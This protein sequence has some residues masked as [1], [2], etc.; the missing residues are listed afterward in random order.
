MRRSPGS[1][2][3]C[4]ERRM[5]TRTE[6][7]TQTGIS[8]AVLCRMRGPQRVGAADEGLPLQ[9]LRRVAPGERRGSERWQTR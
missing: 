1:A 7:H 2:N 3:E 9:V 6:L 8:D 4:E 5:E